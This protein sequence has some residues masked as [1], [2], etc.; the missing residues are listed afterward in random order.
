MRRSHRLALIAAAVA[1]AGGV[2]L[3]EG[4]ASRSGVSIPPPLARAAP[5]PGRPLEGVGRDRASA[6]EAMS[7]DAASAHETR[8]RRA[9]PG[10]AGLGAGPLAPR[11]AADP[12]RGQASPAPSEPHRGGGG[13]AIFLDPP[14]I[15][16]TGV[17]V[18]TGRDAVG[19]RPL[20]L[21]RLLG[22]HRAVVA[23]TSSAA[24]GS[25]AFPPLG[26]GED[27]LVLVAAGQGLGPIGGGASD[28]VEVG[29]RA[30]RAPH[31]RVLGA[32]GPEWALRIEPSETSGRVLLAGADRRVF[33]HFALPATAPG[34]PRSFDVTV[35]GFEAGAELGLAHELPSGARSPWRSV[36]LDDPASPGMEGGW[37]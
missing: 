25:F 17:A 24:G 35:E 11:D 14:R 1:A 16:P 2:R 5:S 27:G 36:R 33:A 23:R 32:F 13:A 26:I 22:S 29:M 8:E 30:P 3:A 4:G 10:T 9:A 31:A 12:A 18:V 28:P 15:E 21:W 20:V 19:P 7:A 34:R 6:G 37:K